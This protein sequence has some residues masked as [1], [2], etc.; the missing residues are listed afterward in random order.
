MCK[1]VIEGKLQSCHYPSHQREYL[2]EARRHFPSTKWSAVKRK[3]Y[4]PNR[5]QCIQRARDS[6]LRRR[7]EVLG[8]A[9][10]WRRYRRLDA[11]I[12]FGGV[13][14]RCSYGRRPE[15]LQFHHVNGDGR[16]ETALWA[17]L[18]NPSLFELLCPNCHKVETS[19]MAKKD[20]GD[21]VS[22]KVF[23]ERVI[24]AI[25]GKCVTCGIT[26][27]RILDFDH[28]EPRF[29]TGHR[30]SA[31]NEFEVRNHPKRFQLLCGNCHWLK[32]FEQ[33]G[34]S[35]FYDFLLGRTDEA[36]RLGKWL[37]VYRG[38]L[39]EKLKGAAS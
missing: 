24:D 17:A 2:R 7:K 19:S 38:R 29:R 10:D 27:K 9:T 22:R 28:I 30:K 16:N 5:Q 37:S 35:P 18:R 36:P 26:D 21:D 13:C 31:R 4:L 8:R 12:R 33:A 11:I 39:L 23:R 14:V 1:V 3:Y 6:Y 25:G 32:T 20:S 34:C 15:I